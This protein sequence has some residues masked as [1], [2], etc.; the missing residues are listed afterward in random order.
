MDPHIFNYPRQLTVPTLPYSIWR[1]LKHI[2][3]TVCR[4][5]C[6]ITNVAVRIYEEV[7]TRRQSVKL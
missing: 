3:H 4:F 2:S 1:M 7:H 5:E 6:H